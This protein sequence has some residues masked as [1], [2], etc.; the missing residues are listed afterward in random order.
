LLLIGCISLHLLF[1]L[2]FGL[3][4]VQFAHVLLDAPLHGRFR[5]IG[6]RYEGLGLWGVACGISDILLQPSLLVEVNMLLVVLNSVLLFELYRVLLS[7]F[8][9][10]EGLAKHIC[11][12]HSQWLSWIVTMT[13]LV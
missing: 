9:L 4:S 8:E 11:R 2:L 5:Y 6:Q 13:R 7:Q 12:S 1:L 10:I 3:L